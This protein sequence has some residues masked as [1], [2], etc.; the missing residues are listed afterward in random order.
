MMLLQYL[1][2]QESKLRASVQQLQ[3]QIQIRLIT[4]AKMKTQPVIQ[5]LQQPI[6]QIRI[7][8]LLRT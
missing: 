5:W 6:Q 7:R 2:L 3:M 1:V 8:K 4:Q